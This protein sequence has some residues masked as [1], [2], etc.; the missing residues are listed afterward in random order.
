MNAAAEIMEVARD[1]TTGELEPKKA[2]REALISAQQLL[3]N[4]TNVPTVEEATDASHLGV[5]SAEVVDQELDVAGLEERM[6][7][8]LRSWRVAREVPA[9]LTTEQISRHLF[10]IQP[11]TTDFKQTNIN[12]LDTPMNHVDASRVTD[13]LNILCKRV[14]TKIDRCILHFPSK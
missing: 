12:V 8:P 2:K 14:V 1:R 3:E 7:P 4:H 9:N 10:G 6:P 5:D 11:A 13:S